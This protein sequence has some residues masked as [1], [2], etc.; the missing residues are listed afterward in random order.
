MGMMKDEVYK[1]MRS[2]KSKWHVLNGMVRLLT[3][4]EEKNKLRCLQI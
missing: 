1:L 3:E 2:G 4:D